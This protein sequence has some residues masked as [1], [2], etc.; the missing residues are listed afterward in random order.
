MS[1]L[2]SLILSLLLHRVSSFISD[3][4]LSFLWSLL[5][6]LILSSPSL[7]S[8]SS[9]ILSC[10]FSS[11]LSFSVSLCLSL[12]V[13]V[14]LSLS[15]CGGVW[16]GVLCVVSCGLCAVCCACL[17]SC[18]EFSRNSGVFYR[19]PVVFTGISGRNQ[20]R[21]SGNHF[22]RHGTSRVRRQVPKSC[23]FLQFISS[24]QS[25]QGAPCSACVGS[26]L[27]TP[28][29]REFTA[30]PVYHQESDTATQCTSD[31]SDLLTNRLNS[32]VHLS[33]PCAGS[34]D[35]RVSSPRPWRGAA[36]NSFSRR[37]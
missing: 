32:V 15:P 30:F 20:K 13:S 7:V 9:L 28:L 11:C 12:S 5:S 33:S 25:F 6:S 1:L 19:M 17:C 37:S 2:S 36:A 4:V 29:F 16:C 35:C 10:L 21:R 31:N 34:L 8:L 26:L 14:S 22:R 3:L 23:T 24:F 18:L 27:E